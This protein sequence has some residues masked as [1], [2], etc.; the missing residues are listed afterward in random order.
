MKAL[1]V[2]FNSIDNQE[3]IKEIDVMHYSTAFEMLK[4]TIEYNYTIYGD[5]K[6]HKT[7]YSNSGRINNIL[8]QLGLKY[9]ALSF[10][11][12]II[13]VTADTSGSLIQQYY[14]LCSN[15]SIIK[16]VTNSIEYNKKEGTA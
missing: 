5:V 10:V 11:Q 14:I 2:K 9:V 12:G 16:K 13:T 4:D 7:T 1:L 6:F 15:S 3:I 8:N